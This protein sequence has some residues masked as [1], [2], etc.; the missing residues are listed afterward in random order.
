MLCSYNLQLVPKHFHHP[1]RNPVP[2][3]VPPHFTVPRL[4]LMC[5]L[6]VIFLNISCKSNRITCELLCLACFTLHDIFKILPC[7][8]HRFFLWWIIF[9]Y[10]DIPQSVYPFIYLSIHWWTFWLFLL[11]NVNSPVNFVYKFLF[12]YPFSIRRVYIPRSGTAGHKFLRNCRIIL[13]N[14]GTF[15][16]SPTM[17]KSSK[18]STCLPALFNL[19][20]TFNHHQWA[21]A[22]LFFFFFK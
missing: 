12:E 19:Y 20:L 8:R 4:A 21:L 15:T 16:S 17:W 2:W 6:S 10:T 18:S 9:Y 13:H 1:R 3:A 7:D 5:F 22:K 14:N 11:D